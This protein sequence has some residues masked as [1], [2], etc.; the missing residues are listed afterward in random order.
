MDVFNALTKGGT[1]TAPYLIK[2]TQGD[3]SLY[4]INDNVS[5]TYDGHI[6]QSSAFEYT[7]PQT[8]GGYLQGGTLEISVIGNSMQELAVLADE[9]LRLDVVG[10]LFD[11]T[12][13]PY[14]SFHHQYGELNATADGVISIE[15]TNDDRMEMTF[16]AEMFDAEN[17]AGNA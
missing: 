2:I 7:P 9:T 4:F 12:V 13:T 5:V 17:N 6:F 10:A 3:T 11:G 1:F 15:F 16:P 14:R 8:I